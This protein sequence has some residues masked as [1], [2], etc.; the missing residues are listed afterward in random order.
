MAAAGCPEQGRRERRTP[1][2]QDDVVEVGTK[3]TAS[4]TSVRLWLQLS[5]ESHREHDNTAGTAEESL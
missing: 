4:Q 2:A 3:G 1:A 5:P